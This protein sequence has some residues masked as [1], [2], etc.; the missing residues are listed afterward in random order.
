M[1]WISSFSAIRSFE[2]TNSG[3]SGGSDRQG[4]QSLCRRDG[5]RP[6]E[7]VITEILVRPDLKIE[8]IVSTGQASPPGF[9]Y[10]Q[11]WDEWVTGAR[12]RRSLAF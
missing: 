3:E 1:R 11:P 12:G 4:R 7:E 10:D 5:N 9:W 2:K 8:R 6:T